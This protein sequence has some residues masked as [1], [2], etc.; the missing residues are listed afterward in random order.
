V[1]GPVVGALVLLLAACSGSAPQATKLPALTSTPSGPSSAS[2]DPNTELAAA[3]AVVRRYYALLNGA[4]T[5]ANADALA[6]LMTPSC[7]CRAV[8][9]STSEVAR[10]GQQYFGTT[11]VLALRASIDGAGIASVLV[12]YDY[13]ASGIRDSNG[14]IVQR[15]PG[16]KGAT[17]N[18]E[19]VKQ[20][21]RWLIDALM[22]ISEGEVTR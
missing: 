21:E 18:F 4:T 22:Y 13:S 6:S 19:L 8:A 1:L 5:V 12:T 3:T 2:A 14:A 9:T 17:V 20:R 10:R 15:F 16:R 11:R 7:K